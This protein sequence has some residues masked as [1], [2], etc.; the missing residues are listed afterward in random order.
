MISYDEEGIRVV[1]LPS[2]PTFPPNPS[3]PPLSFFFYRRPVPCAHS[4]CRFSLLL[5]CPAKTLH[6]L[7]FIV[8]MLSS[9]L[10]SLVALSL[11]GQSVAAPLLK[12]FPMRVCTLS[13]AVPVSR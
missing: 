13:P 2:S 10:I 7:S 3:I 11:V 9:T 1:A 4:T 6:H 12:P 5:S 8:A